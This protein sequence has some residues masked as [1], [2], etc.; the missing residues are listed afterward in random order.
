MTCPRHITET[1]I[2][3]ICALQ[4]KLVRCA[5]IPDYERMTHDVQ[6]VVIAGAGLG[7]LTAALALHQRGIPVRVFETEPVLEPLGSGIT[8]LPSA[9]GILHQLGLARELDRVAVSISE[10]R[11][12]S[13]LGELMW[14][15]DRGLAARF[16][17]P[18]YALH[19]GLLLM[20]L[21]RA[22]TQ[23]LGADSIR[24]G[25]TLDDWRERDDGQGIDVSFKRADGT[26]HTVA[27]TCLIA[28]DGIR[29]AARRKLFPHEGEP[30]YA[31]RMLWHAIS[32]IQPL[33]DGRTMIMAG[34]QDRTFMCYPITPHS[35]SNGQTLVNWT[36]VLR[37]PDG[38][39]PNPAGHP[40]VDRDQFA[41]VFDAM[42][43]AWLGMPEM[44]RSAGKIYA[45]PLVDRDPLAR[46]THG[47]MTLLGDAAHPMNAIGVSGASQAI[48]DADALAG[49]VAA[50]TDIV[51]GLTAYERLR[52]EPTTKI[53]LM[54][55]QQALEQLLQLTEA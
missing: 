16:P 4:L 43:F 5:V 21:S 3:I 49:Q 2:P 10:L 37:Q 32:V 54:S 8:L 18:H 33:L 31:G 52:R 48:L 50:H 24:L 9:A 26:T 44:I 55:R 15:K 14:V 53:V 23:R 28:A 45:C 39:P 34:D 12:A 25:M 35:D 38:A 6:P 17:Y 29:S 47:H 36:A 41:D 30:L 42:R 13:L 51:A 27:G 22:V 20:L 46:W 19:R 11:Y 7:G 1:G 40:E